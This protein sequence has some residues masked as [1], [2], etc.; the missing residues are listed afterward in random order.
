MVYSAQERI[1]VCQKPKY[2]ENPTT[3]DPT[4]APVGGCKAGYTK[5]MGYCY[6]LITD[7]PLNWQD[8]RKHCQNEKPSLDMV[9]DLASI[10][11][12]AEAAF[13]TVLVDKLTETLAWIG[14]NRIGENLFEH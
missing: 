14:G 5:F 11:S 13:V 9:F 7:T 3:V 6:K 2:D 4:Q 1:A 8:A 12:L 10:H